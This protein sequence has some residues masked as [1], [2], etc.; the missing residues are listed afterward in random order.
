MHASKLAGATGRGLTPFVGEAVRIWC[1]FGDLK[2]FAED[3]H[4]V[5]GCAPSKVRI[6][7]LRRC[8]NHGT[9]R[10]IRNQSVVIPD[11]HL[12]QLEHLPVFQAVFAVF[13]L[14]IHEHVEHLERGTNALVRAAIEGDSPRNGIQ[15]KDARARRR[16]GGKMKFVI[17]RRLLC[18]LAA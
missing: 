6:A 2:G 8:A 14:F 5:S 12:E 4:Q 13:H 15:H 18:A 11:E 3:A 10:S 17:P 16:K 7:H 9:L 1:I